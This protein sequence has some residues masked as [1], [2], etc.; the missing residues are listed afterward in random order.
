MER[1]ANWTRRCKYLCR[2]I[3]KEKK[4]EAERIAISFPAASRVYATWATLNC[5]YLTRRTEERS[6][7]ALN[8]SIISLHSGR[9]LV[10]SLCCLQFFVEF[11]LAFKKWIYSRHS[12]ASSPVVLFSFFASHFLSRLAFVCARI[13]VCDGDTDLWPVN[14][15]TCAPCV[16]ASPV[17]TNFELCKLWNQE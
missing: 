17:Y 9:V 3:L 1:N 12:I 5:V 11:F 2:R 4:M 13:D 16:V 10:V 6:T 15:G 8:V 7:D 14:T